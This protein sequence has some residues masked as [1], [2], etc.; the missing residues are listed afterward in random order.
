VQLISV[1]RRVV[2]GMTGGMTGTPLAATPDAH[3]LVL[4]VDLEIA[5]LGPET[6]HINAEDVTLTTCSGM[7][8]TPATDLLGMKSPLGSFNPGDSR[9]GEIQFRLGR[10]EAPAELAVAIQEESR[11]GA[12]ITC[13]LVLDLG[14]T[15]TG[16]VSAGCSAQGGTGQSGAA[17]AAGSGTTATATVDRGDTGG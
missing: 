5:N 13:P 17:G 4:S 12:Q 2:W 1:Q 8:L 6:V 3:V 14:T 11:T 15:A 9:R 16:A 10:D 7:R